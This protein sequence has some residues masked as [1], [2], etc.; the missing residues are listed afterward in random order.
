MQVIDKSISPLL[1]ARGCILDGSLSVSDALEGPYLQLPQAPGNSRPDEYSLVKGQDRSSPAE[2]TNM[3][4]AT[5][6][7][8]ESKE[9]VLIPLISYV[10]CFT[11]L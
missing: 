2:V 3:S 5:Y 6:P 4:A 10:S 8:I 9:T 11:I 7:L 1:I